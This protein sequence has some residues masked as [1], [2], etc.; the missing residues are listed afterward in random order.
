[1]KPVQVGMNISKQ[2]KN[3]GRISANRIICKTQNLFYLEK[4]LFYRQGE[5][6]F[7]KEVQETNLCMKLKIT[8]LC[9]NNVPGLENEL[10]IYLLYLIL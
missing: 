3:A 7:L 8:A 9:L 10:F 2:T 1:M 4:G 6:T 5:V